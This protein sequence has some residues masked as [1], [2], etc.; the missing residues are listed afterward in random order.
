MNDDSSLLSEAFTRTRNDEQ[1]L[2][3]CVQQI[4]RELD[5]VKGIQSYHEDGNHPVDPEH[6]KLGFIKGNNLPLKRKNVA[7]NGIL[8][9]VATRL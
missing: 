8:S 9:D 1:K 2:D 5:D 7:R 3:L 6:I 4:I